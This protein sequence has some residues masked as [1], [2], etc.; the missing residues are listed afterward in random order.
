L[1]WT[2]AMLACNAARS[3]LTS[4]SSSCSVASESSLGGSGRSGSKARPSRYSASAASHFEATKWAFPASFNALACATSSWSV[5]QDCAVQQNEGELGH[6]GS[7]RRRSP[8]APRSGSH[9]QHRTAAYGR[10]NKCKLAIRARR[11]LPPIRLW[12]S[13]D[14]LVTLVVLKPVQGL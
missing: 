7:R 8:P 10:E 2:A 5:A 9:P 3:S 11:T 13:G 1:R 14:L 4:L 6:R 12:R